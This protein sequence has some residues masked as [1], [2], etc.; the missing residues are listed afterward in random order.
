MADEFQFPRGGEHTAVWGRTGSGK[1]QLGAFLLS[2]K[3]LKHSRNVIIDYKGDELLNSL[4]RTREIG[5]NEVPQKPGLY[6]LHSRPD[7]DEDTEAW[8]WKIWEQE[9][10]GLYVDEGYMIPQADKGA[11]AAILTQ[12]RSKRIPV[13]TLSQRPVHVSRFV[14]SEAAHVVMFDL[15]DERDIQTTRGIVPRDFPYWVPP[16]FGTELPMYHARW[17]S[18]KSKSRFVLRPVPGEDQIRDHI[19][20]QLEPKLRWQ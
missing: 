10:I 12:G 19:D 8:L 3:N 5:L 20:R 2:K 4:E 17:Y 7:L 6:I 9:D 14:I 15:N 1:T 16:E 13:I 11:F 18:V